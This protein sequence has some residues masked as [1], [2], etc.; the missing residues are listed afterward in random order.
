MKQIKVITETTEILREKYGATK[1][2]TV[3]TQEE[4]TNEFLT[5]IPEEKIK[6]IDYK[7]DMCVITYLK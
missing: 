2:E 4:N 5:T 6:N 3:K 7:K 1:Y